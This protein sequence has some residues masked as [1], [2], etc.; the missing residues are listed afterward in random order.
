MRN[1]NPSLPR[2]AGSILLLGLS[3]CGGG[4]GGGDPAPVVAAPTVTTFKGTAATGAAMANAAVSISCVSGNGSTTTSA[5]GTYTKDIASVTL[6]C[7]LRAASAD[8]KTALYSVTTVTPTGGN[9]QTANIT[10]LTQLVV[11]SLTGGDPATFFNNFS[12][13]TASSV[14][15]A[16]VATAQTSV[17]NTLTQA[18]IN[19]AGVTDLVAGPITAGSHSGYDGVLDAVQN[20]LASTGTTLAELSTTVAATSPAATAPGTT[21]VDHT[22]RL[23]ANL[24][25]KTAANNCTALRTGDYVFFSPQKGATLAD[26][27]G[28]V[29]FNAANLTFTDPTD[30][31]G[32]GTLVANGNCRYTIGGDQ[33]VVSRAGILMGVNTEAGKTGLTLLIPKQTIAVSELAGSWNALGFEKNGAGTAYVPHALTADVSSGG[34]FT[35]LND[36][37]GGTATDTCAVSTTT[38]NLVT[39]SAGGFDWNGTGTNTWTERAFAYR[40]GS[41]DLML[42]TLGGGGSLTVW[43]KKRTLTL[44]AVG[45]VNPSGWSIRLN[46]QWLT[47]SLDISNKAIIAAVNATTGAVTRTQTTASGAPDYN[48][49]ITINVPRAGYNL[50]TAMTVTATDGRTVT[51]RERTSLP[52]AGMGASVQTFPAISSFQV[53]LDE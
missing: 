17:L 37:T 30:P 28:M 26:Q 52:L 20:Q 10:P 7:A 14:T 12:A 48:D 36:C 51:L 2:I 24:L 40:S 1:N 39:N 31:T 33:F 18:G 44:P 13:G 34:A 9:T 53:T 5:T 46:D 49:V 29:S 15:A 43:T 47:T 41:G 16:N 50:R 45:T 3:A 8:G 22:P 11:A 21:V 23:P 6:P 42:L 27:L 35:N 25:L 32:G 38:I 4:G 19:T